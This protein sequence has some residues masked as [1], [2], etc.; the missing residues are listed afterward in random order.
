MI[1]IGG[2]TKLTRDVEILAGLLAVLECD[3]AD[4][5]LELHFTGGCYTHCA[6]DTPCPE[7]PDYCT[8][9]ER[10]RDTIWRAASRVFTLAATRVNGKVYIVVEGGAVVGQ[11]EYLHGNGA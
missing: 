5:L 2:K 6:F 8:I 1:E 3:Q 11:R 9:T 7:H 4:G 10:H